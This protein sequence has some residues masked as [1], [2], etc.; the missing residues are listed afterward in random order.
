[1]QAPAAPGLCA[2]ASSDICH[3]QRVTEQEMMAAASPDLFMEIVE[4]REIYT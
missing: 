1:M 2:A 3:A 4:R